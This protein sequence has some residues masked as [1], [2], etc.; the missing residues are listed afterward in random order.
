MK[1]LILIIVALLVFSGETMAQ[2][3]SDSPLSKIKMKTLA[4]KDIQ[5]SKFDGKVVVFVNVAS[6]MWLHPAIR[7]VAA[8]A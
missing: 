3:K 6:K 2:S 7:G 1:S 8:I 4:G 5:L